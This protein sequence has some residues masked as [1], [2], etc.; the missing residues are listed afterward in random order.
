MTV[1]T[2]GNVVVDALARAGAKA[3]FAIHGVQ[4]DPIFQAC[5]DSGVALVDVRHEASA[6]F[7]AEAYA[8]VTGNVGAAAVCPGP[9]FTNVLT[10][11][12]NAHIDRTAV[13]YVVGSTPN[14][15]QESNGL[16]V[17]L[18]H[19]AIAAP[20]TKWA[21][22]VATAAHLPRLVAQ[23]IRIATTHPRGP[24]LLDVPADVL[25]APA[26][27]GLV[28]AVAV[29][30]ASVA[31]DDLD[32][33]LARLAA[34]ARPAIV[35][36]HTPSTA[37][38]KAAAALVATSGVPCFTTYGAIGTLADYDALYGGTLYQ[39]ARLAEGAR[40]DV[41]LAVGTAFGFDTPGLRDGGVAWGTAIMHIDGDPAEVGRFASPGGGFIGDPNAALIALAGFTDRHSW[42]VPGE[43][44]ASV[45]AALERTRADLDA[46]ASGSVD[47]DRIH[48]Y[49]AARE[50]SD[51]AAASNAILVG[52]G[53]VCKHWLHDA[54]RLPTGSTY[55]THGRFGC[56][57][58]GPGMAIGAAIAAPGRPVV[59]VVGDGA[60]GFAIGELEA[61]V[62]HGLS[63]TLVVMNN[64]RWGASQGFQLRPGGPQRVV[65][66]TLSDANY[67][68]VMTAFGGTGVR[69]AAVVD[70]R[71]AL[72][73]A[74]GSATPTCIN[75][76][77][78]NEGLAP[79]VPLLNAP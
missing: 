37:A 72:A 53:A 1:R 26:A 17:G 6:G 59:C 8:R 75:V 7:A 33:C 67:H 40:P 25:A 10:S 60:A 49:V 15:S 42:M 66:T 28:H 54:L 16:Q 47:P 38:R 76:S 34:A 22:R 44:R 5:A 51:A 2:G 14:T 23:A 24:A 48:P 57:G 52:D 19:V 20:I 39:L 46:A 11:I 73:A 41:V 78:N 4:I 32:A 30:Q 64:A 77:I 43:W 50:V 9:G 71:T 45:R 12:A 3:V 13:V 18:D 55:L 35:I 61:I 69:V 36:G 68:E 27:D 58:S 29:A 56:M 79:E 65:G 31:S 63:V 70:L 21:C 74:V 62:R